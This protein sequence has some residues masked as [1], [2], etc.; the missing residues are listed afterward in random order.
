MGGDVFNNP[1]FVEHDDL[2][3]EGHRLEPKTVA[4]YEFPE[5]PAAVNYQGSDK[6]RR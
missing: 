6:G 2:G 4:P 1:D 3:D 5:R